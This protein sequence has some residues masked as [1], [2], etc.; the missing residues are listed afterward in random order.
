VDDNCRV[1]W[2]RFRAEL[3]KWRADME[4]HRAEF[5]SFK[6]SLENINTYAT[7]TIR[8]LLILNGGAA[9][10]LLTFIGNQAKDTGFK[11]ANWLPAFEV[12]GWGTFL[13]VL[14][15]A[16]AYLSQVF[17]HEPESL[18][19]KKYVGS[20]LRGLSVIAGAASLIIFIVGV[21]QAKA[22]FAAQVAVH[23]GM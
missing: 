11:A 6:L 17:I 12:F 9:I 19:V 8:S 14:C 3:D 7:I 13:A 20:L 21:Y 23:P 22:A 15:S 16:L 2:E 10:A 1:D 5:D 4:L 18:W